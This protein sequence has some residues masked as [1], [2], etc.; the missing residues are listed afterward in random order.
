[1]VTRDKER[2]YI[3]IKGSVHQEDIIVINIKA[4]NSRVPEYMKKT[5]TELKGKRYQ[6]NNISRL[7]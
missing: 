2:Y 7:Q 5:S 6:H 3:M 4:S 1:M